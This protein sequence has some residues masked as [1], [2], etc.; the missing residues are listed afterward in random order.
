MLSSFQKRL[1][2][3]SIHPIRHKPQ[4]SSFDP[5]CLTIMSVRLKK[6]VSSLSW[7]M[8]LRIKKLRGFMGR[9]IY[10]TNTR[11]SMRS[12]IQK[13][14]VWR[15]LDFYNKG[16]KKLFQDNPSNFHFGCNNLPSRHDREAN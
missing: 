8:E 12:I 10:L 13:K 3:K 2:T 4:L 5:M 11:D 16:T 15:G 9:I 6:M 1:L 14:D 7:I